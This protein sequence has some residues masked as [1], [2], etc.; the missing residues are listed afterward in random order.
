MSD[1][2]TTWS[3]SPRRVSATTSL[4]KLSVF[5]N[6]AYG[7]V[8]TAHS[9]PGVSAS[10]SLLSNTIFLSLLQPA[11]HTA[12]TRT[13][14]T[15]RILLFILFTFTSLDI[16]FYFRVQTQIAVDKIKHW[17]VS[18]LHPFIFSMFRQFILEENSSMGNKDA[19]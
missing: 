11:K 12:A 2:P 3:I 18:Y 10:G 1:F 15:K 13:D 8:T 9:M 17:N 4:S 14:A 5:L 6:A 16:F 7:S 19:V